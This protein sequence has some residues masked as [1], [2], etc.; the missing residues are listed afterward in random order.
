M[1][2]IPGL[3]S[4]GEVW[5]GTVEHERDHYTCHVLTLPGFA[6]QPRIAAPML[7]AVREAIAA[8]ITDARLD[9]PVIVGHS[10]GGFVAL[11]LAASHPDLVGP[12]V[13]VDSQPFLPAAFDPAATVET[14]RA[15]AAAIRQRMLA[16][17]PEARR[18]QERATVRTMVSDPANQAAV[19]GWMTRSDPTAV[20]EAM[21]EMMTTD[22]RPA[23]DRIAARTLVIGTWKG[24]PAATHDGV[25]EVFQAQ[26]AKLRGVQLVIADTARHFVMYDDPAFLFAQIDRFLDPA[27]SAER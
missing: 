16:G 25:A 2:L 15:Q 27:R 7:P 8:Y 11:D 19:L 5:D 3:A 21:T 4:A 26:Y 6:G 18:E 20:V 23:L 10:L 13:I 22:L 17:S 1:I 24:W 9:H 14:A 12:L